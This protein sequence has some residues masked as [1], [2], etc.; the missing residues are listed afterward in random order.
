M[1]LYV[2]KNVFVCLRNVILSVTTSYAG[3]MLFYDCSNST[4][5]NIGLEVVMLNDEP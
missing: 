2:G 1:S 4:A 5:L 3:L